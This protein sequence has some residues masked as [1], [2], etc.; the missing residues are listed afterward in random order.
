MT[1]SA[2]DA[3]LCLLL[4]SA[5]AVTVAS[6]P[7]GS[8]ERDRADAVAESLTSTAA[9]QYTLAPGARRAD[10]SLATFE[11]RAGPEFRRHAHGS[12][13]TLLA[14]AAVRTVRVDG[15]PVTHA[16]DDFAGKARNATRGSLPIRTQVVVR[17]R[18]YPGAHL[19]REFAV[20]PSPPRGADVNAAT[21]RIPGP[22][23]TPE[24]AELVARR[25][26]FEGLAASVSDALVDGLLPRAQTRLA[27]AGDPP[28]STLMRYRYRRFAALYGV[29]VDDAL[30]RGDARAANDRL[31]AAMAD[32]VEADLRASFDEPTEAADHIALGRVDV[33]VRTWS[34]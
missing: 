34:A 19:G 17:W 26:G 30:D 27:L 4:V 11:R 7:D 32:R 33:V 2:L 9:F 22:V 29:D 31:A 24:R 20:G 16:G 10:E 8:P 6:V 25:E 15:D 12:L 23:S 3:C 1:A 14:R 5:A 13:S 21:I 18:P 28:V